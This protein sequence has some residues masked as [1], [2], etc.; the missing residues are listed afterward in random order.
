MLRQ[1]GHQ[2]CPLI[3][4]TGEDV[5][6]ARAEMKN[7]VIFDLD[8]TLADGRH[9]LHALPKKSPEEPRSWDEFNRLSIHDTP[10]YDNIEICNALYADDKEI[11]ILTGRNEIARE[12]TVEWLR[13]HDVHYDRLIM[14]GYDDAR[15]DIYT[16]EEAIKQI[17][18]WNVLCAFD[19]LPHVVKHLRG[20]GITTYQVTEHEDETRVDL[21]SHGSN[22]DE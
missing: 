1:G 7:I 5:D 9:R 13:I 19:D 14:R 12:D 6:G 20:M 22:G 3:L 17:G 2:G 10:I 4:R 18:V 21:Q 11:V 16:K 8:G 15:K